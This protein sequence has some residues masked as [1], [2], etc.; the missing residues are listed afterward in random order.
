[1]NRS[2]P[3]H[4]ASDNC[5]GIAPEAMAAL[6]EA[7]H[8]HAPSYG[9][10][11]WTERACDRI[12]EIF[13]KDCDV[14]FTFT[15]TS[16]NALSLAA[17]AR[18]YHAVLCHERAHVED[19]ECAAPEFFSGGAKL[20]LLPGENGKLT[21]GVIEA[22]ALRN[23]GDFHA[24]KVRAVTIT[25]P[26]EH[27]TLYQRNE[28][29]AIGEACQK[30]GL[31]LHMD[32]ARF[33]NAVVALGCQPADITWR[34][35]VDLISFGLSK[36]GAAVGDTVVFFDRSLAVEFEYRLKQS[37]QLASKMRFLAAQYVG[38]L[39]GDAWLR[40]AAHANAMARRL[41]DGICLLRGASVPHPVEVNFVI[42]ALPQQ[43]ID[44]LRAR[45]WHFYNA[46]KSGEVRLACSW[47]TQTSDVDCF[48]A[49]LK[50]L[51]G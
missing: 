15:G 35:G 3:R 24:S 40:H 51:I 41:A 5:S 43:A 10:D 31:N 45:G 50:E 19:H 44:G 14:Y 32:G 47:D 39:T 27:G 22:E 4:F 18:S 30:L 48:L 36:N 23:R 17:M 21:P 28:I 46:F 7:N 12:R 33:S 16:A 2:K 49:D 42:A 34:A 8:Y 13:E 25:Q 26:T 38:L 37:G 20:V 11:L 1:M 6:V 9:D 29:A